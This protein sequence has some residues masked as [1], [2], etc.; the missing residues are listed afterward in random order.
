[1]PS[2]RRP[3][4]VSS[5]HR[6]EGDPAAAQQGADGDV[7]LHVAS[8]PIDLVDDH[9]LDVALLADPSQHGAQLGPI[10]RACRLTLVQVL[11]DQFPALVADAT[12]A[13]LALGRD[14]EPLF[15]Q[16]LVGLFLGRDP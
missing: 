1:M 16:V 8:Q 4:A 9:G 2:T 12:H 7:V 14:R 5:S 15:G 3:E 13:R 10:G 11:V 6:D